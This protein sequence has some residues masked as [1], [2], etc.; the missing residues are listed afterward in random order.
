M[1]SPIE[2]I[3]LDEKSRKKLTREIEKIMPY[4]I[5]KTLPQIVDPGG[6]KEKIPVGKLFRLYSS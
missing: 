6:L 5:I 4:A 1:I 3:K 2:T